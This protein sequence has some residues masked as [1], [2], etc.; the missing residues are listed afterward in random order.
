MSNKPYKGFEPNWLLTPAPEN[1]YRSIFRWGD[2]NFFKY[3][4]ESL[5][6]LMKEKFQMTDD[7]FKAYSDDTGFDPVEL[8]DHPVQLAPEHID[9]LKAIVGEQNLST[10]DYD[11]LSVAYG[12]TAYDLLRLRHKRVDSVPDVVLYPETTGQVEQIVAYST[13]HHIPLYVYGG[14]WNR[15][16]TSSGNT[17]MHI[18][19]PQ[20]WIAFFDR[21]NAC[22]T[23]RNDSNPAHSYYPTGGWNQYGYAGLDC[24]GYLGWTLYNTLHTKS[25]SVS[26]CDGY[27]APAAEF[28]HT[29]AQRA[30]GTLSRQDCGNGLQEPS[31]FRPGDIFS[32]DGHV[33]LCIGPCRDGS[34]VIAHSTPSPSK[35][36]CK[37]G[38]VQLSALNPA[39]DADK[40]C[41]AYRL[42]ERFM[43]RYSR[44]SARYQA[45]L[46]PYSVYGRL[47]EN[48]HAGLFQWNDF[49]SDKEGVR[50]QFA[51]EILQIEN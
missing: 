44:W 29:L 5:Y 33:W 6:T 9:A 45:Q 50:E 14:G 12:A 37:G 38:G 46:L 26:D 7:D 10:T 11:R 15:Q 4:K 13:E 18:G 28:A 36:D 24:S 23:Y 21:Q 40:D 41:Q 42:A 2:P 3:P 27:V 20:S 51:E 39:S 48:P 16:D 17:A 49:L 47:S 43:Q 31:S 34:I 35:T 25:A 22:Y 19:L 8:P 1:S 30:W 32:M